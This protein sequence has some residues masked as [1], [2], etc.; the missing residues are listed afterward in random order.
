[1]VMERLGD[2][3]VTLREEPEGGVEVE[4]VGLSAAE[5]LGLKGNPGLVSGAVDDVL[6]LD[7][8]GAEDPR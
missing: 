4:G 2:G 8:V 1:M 3:E 5:E 7:C 6:E